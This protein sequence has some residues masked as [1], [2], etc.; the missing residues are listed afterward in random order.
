VEGAAG[1]IVGGVVRGED[2]KRLGGLFAL[3]PGL[4][5]RRVAAAE[6]GRGIGVEDIAAVVGGQGGDEVAGVGKGGGTDVLV[7]VADEALEVAREVPRRRFGADDPGDLVQ[8]GG[9]AP[10]DALVDRSR[11]VGVQLA[12]LRPPRPA[13]GDDDGGKVEGDDGGALRVGRLAR[14]ADEKVAAGEAGR[15]RLDAGGRRESGRE[16]DEGLVFHRR[17][18]EGGRGRRA[19]SAEVKVDEL[20]G[21]G[22]LDEVE[23]MEELAGEGSES[24]ADD[25]GVVAGEASDRPD[26]SRPP[27][28]GRQARADARQG[29]AGHSADFDDLVEGEGLKGWDDLPDN[30]GLGQGGGEVAKGADGSGADAGVGVARQADGLGQNLAFEPVRRKTLRMNGEGGA[31]LERGDLARSHLVD[32]ARAKGGCLLI[33]ARIADP[34]E[35][36][37]PVR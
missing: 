1:W 36:F 32:V 17:W 18:R 14:N 10:A 28:V 29:Q 11:Q 8:R 5:R 2:V 15:G 3:A 31:E 26:D 9:D 35:R 16:G 23:S 19:V 7:G 25:A 6:H 24:D 37:A 20:G 34:R 30:D 21:N 12:Q 13:E 27:D 33:A 4:R 22:R